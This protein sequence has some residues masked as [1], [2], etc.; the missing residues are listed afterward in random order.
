M[1][2]GLTL[3]LVVMSLLMV[4]TTNYIFAL[5]E[6]VYYTEDFNGGGSGD[7]TLGSLDIIDGK[8]H[9]SS[10]VYTDVTIPVDINGKNNLEYAFDLTYMPASTEYRY[11]GVKFWGLNATE[12]AFDSSVSIFLVADQNREYY[13]RIDYHDGTSWQS[14][15][16]NQ[17]DFGGLYPGTLNL[18][19][20]QTARI[21][22]S[23]FEDDLTVFVNQTPVFQNTLTDLGIAKG[24][25]FGSNFVG[26]EKSSGLTI[27]NIIVKS[28]KKIEKLATYQENF[29]YAVIENFDEYTNVAIENGQLVSLDK[30]SNFKLPLKYESPED[31]MIQMDLTFSSIEDKVVEGPSFFGINVFDAVTGVTYEFTIEL[32]AD[33]N[34]YVL[35]KGLNG[36]VI[37]HTGSNGFN[38]LVKAD[39]S[40]NF[41]VQ[42][43]D[44]RI[45]VFVDNVEYLSIMNEAFSRPSGYQ[46][47]TF[48]EY[49]M[50]VDNILVES[51]DIMPIDD[52]LFT[53]D[54]ESLSENDLWTPSNPETAFVITNDKWAESVSVLSQ[55]FPS[56]DESLFKS[57]WKI[58]YD[59]IYPENVVGYFGINIHGIDSSLYELT[60]Q[61]TEG[62]NGYV[63]VKKNGEEF[64]HSNGSGGVKNPTMYVNDR[65][66]IDIYMTNGD[67]EI[68]VNG[69]LTVRTFIS[70]AKAPS[71]I[72]FYSYDAF[73][74]KFGNFKYSMNDYDLPLTSVSI[75]S[76]K[77]KISTLQ[78][79]IISSKLNPSSANI[80]SIEWYIN[81]ALVEDQTGRSLTFG[82]QTPG[83]Y[84]VK[85]IIDGIESNVVTIEVTE[86]SDLELN[87]IYY[88]NFDSM[89]DGSTFGGF[90]I[91]NGKAFSN[92]QT[93]GNKMFDFAFV[94][95]WE[96]S[97][98]ITFYG[99]SEHPTYIGLNILGLVEPNSREF[100]LNL[101]KDKTDSE[102]EDLVV[103]KDTG[104]ETLF[105]HSETYGRMPELNIVNGETYNYRIVR[106]ED[107][108]EI[109]VND[110]LAI[111]TYYSNPAIATRLFLYW[112]NGGGANLEV[113]NLIYRESEEIEDKILPPHVNVESAYIT[114]NKVKAKTGEEVILTLMT[115]PSFATPIDIQ[116][117]VNDELIEGATTK[118]Y[119]FNTD[120]PGTY[121]FKVITD[122]ITSDTR[123]ITI[124]QADVEQP[125]IETNKG[126]SAAETTMII[127]GGVVLLSGL[128]FACYWFFLKKKIK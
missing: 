48:S 62:N 60:V 73:G 120:K 52:E 61:K 104:V 116:W 23:I 55:G 6:D 108:L 97:Y 126:L 15:Y 20:G 7:G 99:E 32:T 102:G 92:H 118:N 21:N 101:K 24:E 2:K 45:K 68:F 103:I 13:L 39:E 41:R 119:S 58:S 63:L 25:M 10:A 128:G 12:G 51:S 78:S 113:D 49:K 96:F 26:E 80:N 22:V 34:S 38:P 125:D 81:D 46:I 124:T 59:I 77:Y 127:I 19:D 115:E 109:W 70:D 47:Y 98:D 114:S 31:W 74:M 91:R 75:Q 72:D 110:E 43:F 86:P 93:Y 1:K 33:G 5:P 42:K 82:S 111:K 71:N 40:L 35:I 90:V 112:Y 106:W 14:Y 44:N 95:N 11:F 50:R 89:T 28:S 121:I 8:A 16:N 27:D 105:N 4:F 30:F 54:F 123:T 3:L 88:E 100:E 65:N 53:L 79:T 83:S 117:Y 94:K 67:L 85:A 64:A 66:H 18:V 84:T 17:S 37:S 9:V 57:N 122:G 76:S 69:Q 87:S 56:F 107:Q 36:D 29:D